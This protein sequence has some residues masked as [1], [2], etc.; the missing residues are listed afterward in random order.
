MRKLG[1]DDTIHAAYLCYVSQAIINNFLPLLFLQLEGEFGI[2]IEK[3]TL[4]ITVNFAIQMGVDLLSVH[5]VDK[6]GYRLSLILSNFLCVAGMLLLGTLPGLIEPYAGLIIAVV[7]CA[8][9][10]GLLEVTVS[11][12]VE[13]CPSENKEKT[14]SLLHSSY[15]WGHVAVI[16]I[17]EL[18][19]LIFG[20]SSWRIMG[21]L[22]AVLP[23]V[24]A[25]LFFKVPVYSLSKG[26]DDEPVG[27]LIRSPVFICM[28]VIL[29]AAGAS[30]QAMAQWASA[31]AESGL[32]VS[33]ALGDLV[34]PLMFAALMGLSRLYFGKSG[35][36]INLRSFMLASGI[37]CVVC[38]L[39][40]GLTGA[41]ALGLIGCALCGLSVGI[42]WPGGYSIA[43]QKLRG[44]STAMFALLAMAGD[45]GCLSGPTLVGLVS[46][47]A[48]GQIRVGLLS[49][50]VF[51]LLLLG[52]LMW[53]S[54]SRKAKTPSL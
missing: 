46:G 19:F 22:W 47:A 18:F 31:F 34:G 17:S 36:K 48:G 21:M 30:E 41:P 35:E 9:G 37:L 39:L 52:A 8:L 6:M 44:G 5:L 27:S 26:K 20:L 50:V 15:C 54:A 51:P 1:A 40:A 14:M 38:Y 7:L 4:L 33:K 25:L 13:A 32:G 29:L 49:A 42:M 28:L 24:A 43:A 3:I 23:C 53:L 10:G 2:S 16:L 45:I 12:L 11:P